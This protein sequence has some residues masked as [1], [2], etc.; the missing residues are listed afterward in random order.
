MKQVSELLILLVAGALSVSFFLWSETRVSAQVTCDVD[1]LN[2]RIDVLVERVTKLEGLMSATK[3]SAKQTAVKETFFQISGG[4]AIGAA[5]W[6]KVAGTDFWFDQ[7]LYGNVSEVTWQGWLDNGSGS[8][9]LYDETN[10]RGVD[11]SEVT[12]TSSNKAS[13]YSKPMAIWR[14]QNQY[15]IQVKNPDVVMMTVSLPRLLI[16]TK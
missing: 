1:C 4:S 12:L 9:R 10:N 6:V 14:G 2:R 15:C 13:F 3:T 16:M 8:V 5:D 11:G 7:S